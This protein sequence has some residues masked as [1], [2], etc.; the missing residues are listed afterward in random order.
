MIILLLGSTGS[1]GTLVLL[2]MWAPDASVSAQHFVQPG[3]SYLCVSRHLLFYEC[4]QTLPRLPCCSCRCSHST[5]SW[6]EIHVL[7]ARGLGWFPTLDR[8]TLFM[9]D[10]IRRTTKGPQIILTTTVTTTI[11][12]VIITVVLMTIL[13]ARTATIMAASMPSKQSDS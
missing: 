11:A 3:L 1:G 10:P 7:K 12:T 6:K 4:L 8:H 2:R 5:S 9:V 13:A